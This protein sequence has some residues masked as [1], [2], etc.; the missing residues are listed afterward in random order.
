MRVMT[1]NLFKGSIWLTCSC[2]G[3]SFTIH[4]TK[5]P[6]C[7]KVDDFHFIW[8]GAYH[9]LLVDSNLDRI[10]HHF[11]DMASFPLP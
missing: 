1:L 11:P 5:N 3:K 2:I 10:F 7:R 6:S 4:K 9:F 8:K